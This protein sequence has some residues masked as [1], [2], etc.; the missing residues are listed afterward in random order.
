MTSPSVTSEVDGVSLWVDEPAFSPLPLAPITPMTTRIRHGGVGSES[1]SKTLHFDL[2]EESKPEKPNQRR[3]SVKTAIRVIAVGIGLYAVAALVGILTRPSPTV[4]VRA[5]CAIPSPERAQFLDASSYSRSNMKVVSHKCS[6]SPQSPHP[7]GMW[8]AC[9]QL[10]RSGV[11]ALDVDVFLSTDDLMFVGHPKDESERLRVP[12]VQDLRSDS[13]IAGGV[14]RLED[15]LSG[16][17]GLGEDIVSVNM[18]PKQRLLTSPALL[19]ALRS[20][21]VA[22]WFTYHSMYRLLIFG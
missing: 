9:A 2:D 17:D 14:L 6:L 20:F 15:F 11:S 10:V 16:V 12:S 22:L 13:L 5:T 8:P 21:A 3:F 18:E 1:T 7:L 19:S 4:G